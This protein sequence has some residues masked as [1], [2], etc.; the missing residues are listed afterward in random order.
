MERDEEFLRLERGAGEQ[1]RDDSM[2][3]NANP[4]VMQVGEEREGGSGGW[5]FLNRK[6]VRLAER[7]MPI[8]F[9]L[10]FDWLPQQI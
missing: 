2:F 1:R 4:C 7:P 6:G 3:P 8:S 5:L 10:L 9:Q